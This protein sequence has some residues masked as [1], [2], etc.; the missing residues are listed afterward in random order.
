M[1]RAAVVT[2]EKLQRIPANG[3]ANRVVWDRLEKRDYPLIA[4]RGLTL[5]PGS[6]GSVVV[7]LQ[8]AVRVIPD[9]AFG[10]KTAAAVRAVQRSANLAQT[11]V[12]GGW[13]W[14]AIENRMP[15]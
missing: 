14:I 5:G 8:R 13:T 9:G 11:G 7:V 12:A 3:V 6:T 4:Y 2:F 1:T 15:R 10:P